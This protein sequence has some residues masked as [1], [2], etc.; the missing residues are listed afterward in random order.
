MIIRVCMDCGKIL[1]QIADDQDGRSHGWCK[2]CFKKRM[3]E[4]DA[5]KLYFRITC[6][7][8]GFVILFHLK[9]YYIKSTFNCL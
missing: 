2:E 5:Q 8:G 6:L 7:G 3:E 9:E 4:S 1:G